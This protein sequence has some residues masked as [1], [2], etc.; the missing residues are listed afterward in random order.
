MLS[1]LENN[2]IIM[3]IFSVEENMKDGSPSMKIE[4]QMV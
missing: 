2:Y 1:E 3:P 4:G